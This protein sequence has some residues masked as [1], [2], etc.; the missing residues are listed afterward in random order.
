VAQAILSDPKP[1]ECAAICSNL[2]ATI[3]EGLEILYEGIQN[4]K[5]N[6][7]RFYIFAVNRDIDITPPA[8]VLRKCALVRI[9]CKLPTTS[10]IDT[11]GNITQLLAA[12]G[13]CVTRID[14]RPSLHLIPFH[15]VYF[16]ELE[17]G[18]TNRAVRNG[19]G[20]RN[21]KSWMK[22]VEDGIQHVI[23]IGAEA[24]FLGSW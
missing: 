3:F 16:V 19:D 5:L 6:S 20:V 24:Q 13:L 10:S 8:E 14:R 9:S 18:N 2:C 21:D 1:A 7:T 4:E 23:E 15:D 22:A 12:L 17:E 11:P